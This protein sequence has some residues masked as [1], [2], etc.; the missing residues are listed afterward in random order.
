MAD[1]PRRSKS[2]WRCMSARSITAISARLADRL[3]FT[4]LGPA[5]NLVSRIER[6]AKALD[7]PILVSSDFARALG[8]GV[9]S[10]GLHHLR[11]LAIPHELYAPA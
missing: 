1:E 4:V 3:D 5:V 2:S 11:G 10:V 9:V 7:R 8:D 6:V